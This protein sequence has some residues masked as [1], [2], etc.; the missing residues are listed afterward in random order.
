MLS[1][2]LKWAHQVKQAV[3]SISILKGTFTNLDVRSFK[4]LYGALIRP[5]LEYAVGI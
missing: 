3:R 4:H 2:D 1:N 5:H